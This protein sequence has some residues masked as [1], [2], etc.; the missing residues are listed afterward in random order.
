[1]KRNPKETIIQFA[2]P[3]I[4]IIV[5]YLVILVIREVYGDDSKF[6]KSLGESFI[7]ISLLPLLTGNI[8]FFPAKQLVSE[9]EKGLEK[10]LKLMGMNS[11]SNLAAAWLIQ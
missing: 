2:L 3:T 4:V 5:I 1:M 8:M 6:F 11:S 10:H 9:R 7:Q